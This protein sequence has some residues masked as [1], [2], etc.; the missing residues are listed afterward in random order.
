MLTYTTYVIVILTS[1]WTG[2]D[3]HHLQISSS[4]KPY[5][6]NNGSLSW[7]FCCLLI[8]I[9]AF[10]AYLFKRA[11]AL[12]ERGTQSSNSTLTSLLGALAVIAVLFCIVE[13]F[14]GR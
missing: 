10:P 14:L 1:T 11:K 8:W 12:K 5:S 3:S 2:I 7:L 13:P 6:W 4:K 9:I